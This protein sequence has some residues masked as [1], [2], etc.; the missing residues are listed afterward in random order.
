M[1]P[2]KLRVLSSEV[3]SFYHEAL[4]APIADQVTTEQVW[5]YETEDNAFLRDW[6]WFHM[7]WPEWYLSSDFEANE[8]FIDRL[9]RAG[10]RILWTQ[11]NL[12][13]HDQDPAMVPVY[14]LW[15]SAADAVSHH[16]QWGMRRA[17]ETYRYRPDV[18]HRVI[19]LMWFGEDAPDRTDADRAAVE[20]ELGLGPSN[21]RLGVIGAPRP[22]KRIDL[23]ME[24]VV[25]C[26]RQDVELVVF[27]LGAGQSAPDDPRVV[28]LPYERV[29][30]QVF[31][32]RLRAL[33]VVVLPFE[34]GL[35]LTTGT[36]G[37]V[38]GAGLAA[39]TS[40]WEYLAEAL[41]FAAIRYGQTADD[42]T[43]CI[44]QLNPADI[45]RAGAAARALRS[46]YDRRR[47]ARL[48]LEFLRD[49]MAGRS[50]R[51]A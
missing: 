47:V 1:T 44:E 10:V 25:Q 3:T 5:L 23:V 50:S 39:L 41:G 34:P 33:D 21:L 26:T 14:E 37:D 16:S 8:L 17:I 29:P 28:G 31:D 45:D 32:R 27:S 30:R 20:A 36:V 35:M 43:A 13:P 12:V 24:A 6:D 2:S 38:V 9:R 51:S 18:V 40:D 42:L 7:H 49:V 11:H 48:H 4:Y 15:A 22:A 19:P 46:R